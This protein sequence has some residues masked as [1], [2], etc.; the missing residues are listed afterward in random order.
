MGNKLSVSIFMVAFENVSTA[1]GLRLEKVIKATTND[2]LTRKKSTPQKRYLAIFNVLP[3]GP[4]LGIPFPSD[5]ILDGWH[6]VSN[7][8]SF[9]S[10]GENKAGLDHFLCQYLVEHSEDIHVN[11]EKKWKVF[12][13]FSKCHS[14]F[15]VCSFSRGNKELEKLPP[16]FSVLELHAARANYMYQAKIWLQTNLHTM[17]ILLEVGR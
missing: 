8:H 17:E 7:E 10:S 14:T 16:T 1:G 5:S 13:D 11:C 9:I 12:K 15:Y 4:L 2:Q 3:Y 6:L